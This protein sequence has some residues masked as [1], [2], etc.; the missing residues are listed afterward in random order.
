MTY[1]PSVKNAPEVTDYNLAKKQMQKVYDLYIIH[2]T[3][4][5]KRKENI[6]SVKSRFAE[7]NFI[8]DIV[9]IDKLNCK[10]LTLSNIKNLLRTKKPDSLDDIE[11]LFDKFQRPLSLPNISNYLKH[12]SALERIAKS[13]RTGLVIEDDVI[14]SDDCEVV[15][16]KYCPPA[17]Q[18]I[19]F[20]G[21]PF[22]RDPESQ[23]QQIKNFN[24]NTMTL[25][26]SV[27][28]YIVDGEAAKQMIPEMLPIA[29]QTNI[30]MSLCINRLKLNAMKMY[31][32]IF[33]D[34]SK[35]GK[36]TSSINPNNI[37]TFNSKYNILYSMIQSDDVDLEKFDEVYSSAEF[38][39]TS[40]DMIYMRALCLLKA[41]KIIESK[42]LFDVAYEKFCDDKCS[43]N[44]N[45]S[46]MCNYLKFF[47]ILQ[48]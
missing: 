17:Q 30:A 6:E 44:K 9:V 18:G 45:S 46:F 12:V 5:I 47:K 39:D 33:I 23:F 36:F 29:Y 13:G 48:Q 32:N 40:P 22:Q 20:F 35:V 34:G 31:P 15:L 2:D 1:I 26:P 11:I 7:C 41:G 21:Q 37:L 4:L 43:L 38:N 14:M 25:L 19:V 42:Q 10:D 16:S 28:S 3:N 24:G 27:E 8:N